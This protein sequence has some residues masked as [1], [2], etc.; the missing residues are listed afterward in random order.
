MTQR[1]APKTHKE[2]LSEKTD[3]LSNYENQQTD[4]IP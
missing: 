4:L 2:L 1:K 3:M